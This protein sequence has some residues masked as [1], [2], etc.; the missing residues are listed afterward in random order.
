M[1]ALSER[2]EQ[3]EDAILNCFPAAGQILAIESEQNQL[4]ESAC[5]LCIE[6]ASV[7]RAA[8]A[9]DAPSSGSAVLRLQYEALLRAA[10]LIFVASP[11]LISKLSRD[12]TPEAELVAK[13]LPSAGEMLAKVL[14]AAP[15]GLTVH[16]AEFNQ[17]SRHALNS[18]VHA[19]IH[20]LRRVRDGFPEEMAL[21]LIRI[22]NGL[23]HIAYRMLA[24]LTGSQRRMDRVTHLYK[25]FTD[26]CP[27]ASTGH[28]SPQD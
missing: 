15:A 20:P 19:G 13:N 24:M 2:S 12:L 5:L 4:A 17:Y 21:T 1:L 6:H 22:S 14:E 10:W 3:F 18:Y 23:M 26:C 27:M 11:A 9:M 8:F 28:I 25:N 16:L 7:V